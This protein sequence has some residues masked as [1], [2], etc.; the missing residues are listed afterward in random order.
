MPIRLP[1]LPPAPT[2]AQLDALFGQSELFLPA[3]EAIAARHRLPTGIVRIPVGSNVLFALGATHVLKLFAPLFH[4]EYVRELRAYETSAAALRLPIPELVAHGELDGWTYM[5]L[6][7]VPGEPVVKVWQEVPAGER[8]AIAA[9]L[10]EAAAMLHRAPPPASL[11]VNWPLFLASQRANATLIQQGRDGP[12]DWVAQIDGFL[13]RYAPAPTAAP[14][15]LLHA[16][17][18]NQNVL[19]ER[20]RGRWRLGGVID[21]GDAFVGA[22][23]YEFAAPAL[24]ICQ[25]ERPLLASFL[26]GYGYAPRGEDLACRLLAWTLL[27]RFCY[28]RSVRKILLPRRPRK[29]ESLAEQLFGGT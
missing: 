29:L 16:D 15:V 24:W 1:V 5:A 21:F 7:R 25:G 10:G 3:V 12:A 28:L 8:V 4:D 22:R 27:H 20:R 18:H 2:D 19:L 23:E 26:D 13:D 14:L 6:T 9:Q 17:L 11:A